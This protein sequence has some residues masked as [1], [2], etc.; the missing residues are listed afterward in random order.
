MI[1]IRFSASGTWLFDH[2]YG[3]HLPVILVCFPPGLSRH[4]A[5]YCFW[6]LLSGCLFC[7][8]AK[9]S[10]FRSVQFIQLSV[11]TAA[12]FAAFD[13]WLFCGT[14]C[15]SLPAFNCRSRIFIPAARFALICFRFS[16]EIHFLKLHLLR[17]PAIEYCQRSVI[18]ILFL[19]TGS[20]FFRQ[21]FHLGVHLSAPVSGHHF[22]FAY[23]SLWFG[24]IQQMICSVSGFFK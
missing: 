11:D 20:G 17:V 21:V 2:R 22:Q 12:S 23:C 16:P 10:N 13:V 4:H 24:I 6:A 15:L 14:V 5:G 7:L 18:L 3:F 9:P 8:P 19:C 1:V